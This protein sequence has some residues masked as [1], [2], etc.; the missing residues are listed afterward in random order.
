MVVDQHEAAATDAAR[1]RV[2]DADGKRGRHRRIDGVAPR[3]E[4]L[5]AGLRGELMLGGD[6]AVA[7]ADRVRRNGEGERG[8]GGEQV[9]TCGRADART[10]GS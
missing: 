9:L 3:L 7:A 2:G 1:G 6:H 8:E 10:F 4:D 5:H